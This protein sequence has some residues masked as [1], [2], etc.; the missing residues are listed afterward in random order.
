MFRSLFFL[1]FSCFLLLSLSAFPLPFQEKKEFVFAVCTFV[2]I[3][4]LYTEEQLTFCEPTDERMA[5]LEKC[6]RCMEDTKVQ[7]KE[8]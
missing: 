8:K 5:L 6:L 4:V 2:D 7:G 3:V 1:H